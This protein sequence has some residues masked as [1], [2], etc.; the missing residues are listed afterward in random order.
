MKVAKT[1]EFEPEEVILQEG[2]IGENFYLI[3][4]GEVEARKGHFSQTRLLEIRI[5]QGSVLGEMAFLL[6]VPRSMTVVA[7]TP[8]KLIEIDQ[9]QFNELLEAKLTAPYKLIKNIAVILAERL[10]SL[11]SSHQRL[12]EAQE[13]SSQ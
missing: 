12:L 10:H 13:K 2:A 4:E 7:A 8:C 9:E 1:L 6:H 5:G 11:T 3:L